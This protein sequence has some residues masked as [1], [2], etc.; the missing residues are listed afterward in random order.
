[1]DL[2]SQCATM[3]ARSG[4][5]AEPY[6]GTDARR[7]AVD[8]NRARRAARAARAR[9]RRRRRGSGRPRPRRR[10][11]RRSPRASRRCAACGSS[12]DLCRQRVSPAQARREGLEDL[13]RSYPE[14]RRKAD[15]EVLKLLGL[16]EPDVDLRSLSGSIFGEGV[17]G[18][19]DPRSKRLRIVRGTTPG[20]A[21]RDGARARAHARARGP[22]LR[23]ALDG[24]RERR[25]RAGPARARRGLG[26]ARHA[27]VPA[28]PHRRRA[29][30][31]AALLG[32]A[33]SD[34]PRPAEVP[35][36]PADLPVPERD[37]VRPG[38]AGSRA[39]GRGRC[40]DLAD[41]VR[42][43]DSTEQI[44]HPE[45]WVEVEGPLPRARWTS[46]SARAGAGRRAAPGAS[47]RRASCSIGGDAA[48]GWGGDRYELWQRGTCAAPPCRGED[49]LVMRW[50]W[51][52]R[53]GRARVRGRAARG[54]GREWRRCRGAAP[55]ATPSRSCWRPS[56]ALARRAQ[57]LAP[58]DGRRPLRRR[59]VDDVVE[60]LVDLG[61]HPRLL[62]LGQAPVLDGLVE[63]AR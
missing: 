35:P 34:R 61:E 51:D 16:I 20:R 19:Y 8:G 15:E 49:V 4:M 28:A 32:S 53:R 2:I 48:A 45:K 58:A 36:G 22:A 43:P 57:R 60:A 40:V 12:P 42:V 47:G 29:G 5:R 6:A 24:G 30:A 23:A 13:D 18:Y 39:A 9:G 21:E 10:R 44:L 63:L 33:F 56:A 38:A 25:R 26:D 55:A 37:A 31:R 62:R 41:R 1:M 11:S 17:A 27:A 3:A 7:L 54:P 59:A 14:S 46:S 50:R 52:T